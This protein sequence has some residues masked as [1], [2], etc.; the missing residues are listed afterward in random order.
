MTQYGTAFH[1]YFSMSFYRHLYLDWFPMKPVD[2][3]NIRIFPL[4]HIFKLEIL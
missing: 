2:K 1:V 4:T 3:F